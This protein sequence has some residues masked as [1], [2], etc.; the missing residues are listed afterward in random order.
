LKWDIEILVR[1]KTIAP[2]ALPSLVAEHRL[3]AVEVI[4]SSSVIQVEILFLAIVELG[5]KS[6]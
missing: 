2:V 5:E 6:E 3:P 1:T 4:G